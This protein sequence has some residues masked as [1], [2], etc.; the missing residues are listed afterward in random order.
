[1]AWTSESEPDETRTRKNVF[2]L[3]LD[4]TK[5][6]TQPCST[7]FFAATTQSFSES[8]VTPGTGLFQTLSF[9]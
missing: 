3:F 1:M 7:K 2:S 5:H 4:D 9:S 6:T 8:P